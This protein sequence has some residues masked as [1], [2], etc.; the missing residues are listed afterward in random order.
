MA[1]SLESQPNKPGPKPEIFTDNQILKRL[2]LEVKGSKLF[3]TFNIKKYPNEIIRRNQMDANLF[4]KRKRKN[5]DKKKEE[6]TMVS[7]I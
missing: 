5:A 1:E 4:K 7:V 6:A 3:Q 2:N